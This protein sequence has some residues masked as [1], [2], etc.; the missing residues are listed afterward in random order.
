MANIYWSDIASILSGGVTCMSEVT[1]STDTGVYVVQLDDYDTVRELHRVIGAAINAWER[2]ESGDAW[3]T[4]DNGNP[5]S[6]KAHPMPPSGPL[7]IEDVNMFLAW[8]ADG[9]PKT[10]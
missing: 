7:P 1:V 2:T 5:I 4:D 9:M 8:V 3:Q 6:T 10:A